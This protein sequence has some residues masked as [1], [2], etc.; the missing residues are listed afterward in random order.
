MNKL[1]GFLNP[2]A[3]L[4]LQKYS[5]LFPLIA[6]IAAVVLS[7]LFAY[8]I[9]K[10]PDIVGVYII[11]VN[12]AMIIYFA[13][14]DG[15][16]GGFVATIIP[17]IY[18]FYIVFTR[19]TQGDEL[20]SALKTIGMLT[21]VYLILA[22]TIGWLK[23]RIDSLIIKETEA[24]LISE[25]RQA[26]LQIILQQLPV[27]VLSIDS[28]GKTLTGNRQVEKMFGQK[29]RTPKDI[30][31]NYISPQ[32]R[33]WPIIRA[34]KKGE[35]I[36]SEEMEYVKNGNKNLSLLVNAAPIK[37][38][39]GQIIAAVSVIHDI[40]K[41]KELEQRKDDFI[42]MA[43]HELKT[44]ITSM[45]I[46]IEVLLNLIKKHKDEKATKTL[47]S[48][49]NQTEKLQELVSDLLDVSRIQTGKLSFNKDL[50]SLDQL[51]KETVEVLQ[52]TTERHKINIMGRSSV[53]V[54]ADRFRI[55]QVLTNL[56]TNAIK[57]SPDAN[58]INVSIKKTDK[59][60]VVSVQDFGI[61]ISKEQ[62]KKVFERLYQVTDPKEKTFPGLGMGLYISKE[63]IKR[64]KGNIW[65]EG[66]KG[67]GSI[68]FFSLPL[69]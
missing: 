61:G 65:V 48:I 56:I 18:Y 19:G 68:F 49:K 20:N 53:R 69:G 39:N 55:Y 23:M 42:N 8:Q 12:V 13:F 58:K 10:N 44:P 9:A 22:A 54:F 59:K 25:E 26:R 40:T 51:V 46:Y 32:S 27:G 1:T 2:I 36:R 17:I 5:I 50:F 4:G 31:E 37:N 45:K 24:R 28:N 38:R 66:E 35:T 14:R 41:E 16:K 30:L 7:E 34:L 15:I 43:S 52:G 29:I 57:Y 67:K 21:A 3:R 6:S 47:N 64:H 63:I 62:Q 11:F 33:E 60:V